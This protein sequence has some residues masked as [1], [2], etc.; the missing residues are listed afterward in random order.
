MLKWAL[1]KLQH[2]RAASMAKDIIKR[3]LELIN[4]V[5]GADRLCMSYIDYYHGDRERL[6]RLRCGRLKDDEKMFPASA[7]RNAA[8]HS[9]MNAKL[10]IEGGAAD[11]GTES[12]LKIAEK[13]FVL[14]FLHIEKSDL[15]HVKED[16]LGAAL[17]QS[18]A[19][20]LQTQ[21]TMAAYSIL[22][23]KKV[24]DERL[25]QGEE[26]L[27]AWRRYDPH[28]FTFG[29]DVEIKTSEKGQG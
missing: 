17:E 28:D 3:D 24:C 25:R 18:M 11:S 12:M 6:I 22:P 21:D 27:E 20:V 1:D 4:Q 2:A 13:S 10:K 29:C 16:E 23:H 9:M 19:I 15:A 14:S 5:G 7:V 8:I 26:A